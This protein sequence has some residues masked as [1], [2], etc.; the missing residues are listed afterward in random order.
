MIVERIFQLKKYSQALSHI[1]N[2]FTF[3]DDRKTNYKTLKYILR[4]KDLDF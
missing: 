2:Y 3:A 1:K 4:N